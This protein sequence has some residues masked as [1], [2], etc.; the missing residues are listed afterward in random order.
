[1]KRLKHASMM[2]VLILGLMGTI[3]SSGMGSRRCTGKGQL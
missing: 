1:M 2:A 3:L